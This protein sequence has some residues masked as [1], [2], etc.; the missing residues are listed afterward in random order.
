MS[1]FP[2][3]CDSDFI[4]A[5]VRKCKCCDAFFVKFKKCDCP[6]GPTGPTGAS[7]GTGQ[8]GPTGS[9]GGTGPT[10]P[11][12]PIGIGLPG[13]AGPAGAAGAAGAP[14]AVGPAGPPGPAGT[15]DIG[16]FGYVFNETPQVV[17]INAPVLFDN[18]AFL[19][20]ITHTPGVAPPAEEI[21][22]VTPGLY[23]VDWSV[24]GTEPNQFALFV[25]GAP[26]IGTRYGSG[27]GTQQ[28]T[29]IQIVELDAGDVVTLVNNASAAAVTLTNPIGGTLFVVNASVRFIL[30]QGA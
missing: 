3:K 2:K 20:G 30:L 27:A 19:V 28:N 9:T 1:R 29:G 11:A 22:I 24:S 10:G 6:V 5:P 8:T 18:N 23:S 21:N 7:G 14:G 17:A 25:N 4:T 12:G 15:A 16:A 26:P 13:P